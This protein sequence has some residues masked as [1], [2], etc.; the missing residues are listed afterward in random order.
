MSEDPS[1][2]VDPPAADSATL[3]ADAH[4]STTPIERSQ[5]ALSWITQLGS[6]S[7][8]PSTAH[9][10]PASLT[11]S[12]IGGTDLLSDLELSRVF[13]RPSSAPPSSHSGEESS[14]SAPH[15]GDH[16]SALVFPRLGLDTGTRETSSEGPTLR[17]IVTGGSGA[18]F[19]SADTS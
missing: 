18:S 17:L 7:G 13:P 9:G 11:A 8:A 4:E 5:A 2:P 16:A 1:T 3:D 14:G 12:S 6:I 19:S 10:S 15:S